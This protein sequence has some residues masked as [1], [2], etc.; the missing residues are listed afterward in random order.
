M[1]LKGDNKKVKVLAMKQKTKKDQDGVR[2]LQKL[3]GD[4]HALLKSHEVVTKQ[5]N[6]P[7]KNKTTSSTFANPAA[8]A[9][10]A[11]NIGSLAKPKE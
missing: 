4:T 7:P 10:R 6:E 9:K 2:Q 3:L 8:P 11:D 5:S 1:W